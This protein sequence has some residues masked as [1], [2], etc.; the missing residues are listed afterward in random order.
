MG[1]GSGDKEGRGGRGKHASSGG[2][3]GGGGSAAGS[4]PASAN[5]HNP[6]QATTSMDAAGAAAVSRNGHGPL[7]PTAHPSSMNGAPNGAYANGNS[8][9]HWKLSKVF[10]ENDEAMI[11]RKLPE[12]LL[13]RV[14]SH[15]DVISL[16]RCAQVSRAWNILALDGSNWQ[17][18]DLFSFQTDIEGIVVEN[19][20]RRCGG[21]L[22][23]LS[24]KGCQQGSYSVLS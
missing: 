19:I 14:F 16:C 11:N 9:G 4:S 8:G 24:L 7:A 2:G 22:R 5:N 18:V 15:L 10:N 13:L 21:F 3:S 6:P 17:R 20:A 23:K 1:R 12:E